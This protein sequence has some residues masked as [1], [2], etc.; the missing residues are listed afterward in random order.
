M[1]KI[2]EVLG[3]E[4]SMKQISQIASMLNQDSSQDDK[5]AD[6]APGNNNINNNNGNDTQAPDFDIAKIMKLKDIMQKS[7]K[8][9][10]STDLLYA[11]RPLVK[12]ETQ[13][14]IDKL[15]KI[16]RIISLLPLLKESGILGGDF[17]GLI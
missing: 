9:D 16:F 2:Q 10:P 5:N 6:F 17:L 3:D 15:L 8:K 1:S 13:I 12:S 4:E 11:L 7:K 14:K